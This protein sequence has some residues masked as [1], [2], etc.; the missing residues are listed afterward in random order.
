MQGLLPRY[1][2]EVRALLGYASKKLP[3]GRSDMSERTDITTQT[4]R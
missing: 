4:R 1:E 3:L 2:D